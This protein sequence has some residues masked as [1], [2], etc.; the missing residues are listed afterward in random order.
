VTHPHALTPEQLAAY[1][2]D[3]AL[4]LKGVVPQQVIRDLRALFEQTVDTLATQWHQE[5]F[6]A[7]ACADRPF[8]TRFA[9]LRE[10]LP[11]RFPTSWRKILVSPTVYGLWQLPELLGPMRS[12]LGDEV[13]AH[14]VWNGRPR[15]PNNPIQKV[16]WHQ[17]AHY[18]RDWDAADGKLVSVWIPIVPVDEESACLE[19]ALGS[20]TEGRFERFRGVNRLFTVADADLDGYERRAFRMEPGDALAF[21]DTTLHQSLDNVSDH[22]R[23][24]IDIRFGEATPQVISKT[25]RGY[26]CFSASDPSRVEPYEAWADRYD[27]S[28]VGLDAEIEDLDTD[29][30][31]DEAA[32]V[33]GISRSELEVF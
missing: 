33:L 28:K 11:A 15:E 14:G 26:Y 31:L 16:L 5:G 17:D 3:G 25:P 30:D 7:D 20:H 12:I 19:M 9:G 6:V 29:A 2:R 10:Q 32:Q 27:Y 8:E 13:Y 1:D 4:L 18:Y 24:S 23:W 22:V 21:T